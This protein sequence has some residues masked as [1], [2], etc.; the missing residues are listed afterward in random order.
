MNGGDVLQPLDMSG[1]VTRNVN[2][3]IGL[4]PDRRVRFEVTRHGQSGDTEP[5]EYAKLIQ[6]ID[7]YNKRY[8]YGGESVAQFVASRGAQQAKQ[9]SKHVVAHSVSRC[10]CTFNLLTII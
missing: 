10:H 3:K 4:L 5:F 2:A 1:L 6:H 9:L 7:N 8:P